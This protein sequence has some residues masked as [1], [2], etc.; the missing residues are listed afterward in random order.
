MGEAIRATVA[1][2]GIDVGKRSHSACGLDKEPDFEPTPELTSLYP[3]VNANTPGAKEIW[4][5]ASSGV[6]YANP[7]GTYAPEEFI[8]RRDVA[9]M[10]YSV[11]KIRVKR[12]QSEKER[13]AKRKY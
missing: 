5:L 6:S 1:Y 8:T 10:F 7:D 9:I 12:L 13:K 2:L 4:W 3:D 11:H